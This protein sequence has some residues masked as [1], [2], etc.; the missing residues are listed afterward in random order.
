MKKK[1]KSKVPITDWDAFRLKFVK[2]TLRR[3]SFSWPP[4]GQ[5]LRA[6]RTTQKINP[7][8]GRLCWHVAC[9]SCKSEMLEKEGR[10]DHDKP[11]V[12]L[13]EEE[14]YG[15]SIDSSTRAIFYL[16][17]YLFRMFPE[18]NGF[19]V[20]CEQCHT[21]KTKGENSA[22]R[23]N[24]SGIRESGGEGRWGEATM[25]PAPLEGPVR[26]CQGSD[27]RSKEVQPKWVEECSKC[28]GKIPGSLAPSPLCYQ[29]WRKG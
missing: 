14:M 9:A 28:K 10:L 24:R 5:A 7:A 21:T 2:Y 18:A 11:V 20:L 12:S 15:V 3:A 17:T 1:D 22:R 16:G 4:R 19:K 25:E 6:A 8:T 29:C 27:L 13:K 26:Y 23:A